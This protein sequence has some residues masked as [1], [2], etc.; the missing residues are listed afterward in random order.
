MHVKYIKRISYWHLILE[1]FNVYTFAYHHNYTPEAVANGLQIF[2][3][4]KMLYE[5]LWND[6]FMKVEGEVAFY[7]QVLAPILPIVKLHNVDQICLYL[8]TRLFTCMGQAISHFLFVELKLTTLELEI[9]CETIQVN[10]H[11]T[12]HANIKHGTKQCMTAN[13]PIMQPEG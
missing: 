4:V 9:I 1:E 10:P 5:W 2:L 8:T 6:P 11:S 13:N 7:L 12:I 3:L